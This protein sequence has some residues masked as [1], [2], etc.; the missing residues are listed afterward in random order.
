[1]GRIEKPNQLKRVADA[2]S[3]SN[4]AEDIGNQIAADNYKYNNIGQL[5]ENVEEKIS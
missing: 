4:N 5:I 1:M 3:K 2:S